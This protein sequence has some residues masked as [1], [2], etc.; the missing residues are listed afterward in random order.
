MNPLLTMKRFVFRAVVFIPVL[1]SATV[2]AVQPVPEPASR[3]QWVHIPS[4]DE[5]R[6]FYLDRSS[7]RVIDG[8][9]EAWDVVIYSDVTQKDSS[10]GRTIKE[11]R[12]YRRSSCSRNDQALLK[13]AIFDEDGKLIESVAQPYESAPKVFIPYGTIAWSQLI[14][15]CEL[16]GLPTPQPFVNGVKAPSN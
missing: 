6:N 11:K 3:P 7:V 4:T 5:S 13:G 14:I 8:D 15:A 12:T 9:V 1:T 2:F 10:S 16:A